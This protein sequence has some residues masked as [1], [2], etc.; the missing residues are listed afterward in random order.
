MT[1]WCIKTY[2]LT[3]SFRIVFAS[4]C[5]NAIRHQLFQ[6]F[7]NKKRKTNCV[8]FHEFVGFHIEFH[9]VCRNSLVWIAI[10]WHCRHRRR[11]RLLTA[12]AAVITNIN[13][14]SRR[15]HHQYWW[16]A[17]TWSE[18]GN[19][20]SERKNNN[21]NTQFEHM[22]LQNDKNGKIKM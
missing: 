9:A 6:W 22:F 17:R 19:K 16:F 11:C 18:N 15:R 2:Q 12:T 13:S 20:T 5:T 7:Q 10:C 14:S 8:H 4:A 21:P 3:S 1:I